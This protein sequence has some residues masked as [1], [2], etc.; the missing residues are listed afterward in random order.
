MSS[1]LSTRGIVFRVVGLLALVVAATWASH[2]IRDALDLQIKPENEQQVHRAVMVGAVAYIGLLA[3][4][5]VPGAEIGI[6]MLTAFGAAIAPL[7]YSATVL[8][9]LLAYAVGRLI[10]V[11]VLAALLSFFR[12][13][14]AAELISRAAQ[15]PEEAR[16]AMLLDGAPPRLIDRALRH[17]YV[18]LALAVNVPGN[19]IFGGGGGIMMLAG[20]SGLF[21]PIPTVL[22]ILIAVSPVPIAVMLFGL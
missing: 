3:I 20:M 18:A 2:L 19:A 12:M 14:K 1:R 4:P 17:R 22:S 8:A 7:V 16:I 21:A 5:F 6:A 15:L 10:P 13:R 11:R 9:M